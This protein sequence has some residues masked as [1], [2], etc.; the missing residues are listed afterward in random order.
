MLIDTQ[1]TMSATTTTPA[2]IHFISIT[3][4][5]R[6]LEEAAQQVSASSSQPPLTHRAASALPVAIPAQTGTVPARVARARGVQLVSGVTHGND[7]PTHH[8]N[9]QHAGAVLARPEAAGREAQ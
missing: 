8:R 3:I 6:Q 4:A 2:M 7:D 9:T 5:R 1:V